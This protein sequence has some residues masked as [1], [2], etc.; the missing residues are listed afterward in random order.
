M[1]LLDHK[2][3]LLLVFRDTSILFSLVA[4]PIYI[5]VNSVGGF[6]FPTPSPALVICRRNFEQVLKKFISFLFSDGENETQKVACS[7]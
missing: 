2:A 7:R 3:T 1:G 4:A 6:P 5:P